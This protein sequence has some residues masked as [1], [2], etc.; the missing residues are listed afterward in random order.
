MTQDVS[1]GYLMWRWP[2][3]WELPLHY[4]PMAVSLHLCFP[5]GCSR[6]LPLVACR[7]LFPW[8]QFT[9]NRI[10]FSNVSWQFGH[11]SF[12][13]GHFFLLGVGPRL[14]MKWAGGC[15]LLWPHNSLSKSCCPS[16]QAGR[17]I[18]MSSGLCHGQSS[19]VPCERQSLFAYP[20]HTPGV[21][22]YEAR[23]H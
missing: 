21:S 6:R 23:R 18:L 4:T 12:I 2:L 11:S 3:I 1:Y 5:L 10:V 22:V 13:L 14:D 9:E 15:Q 8:S 17:R 16:L 20:R 19:L 7:F